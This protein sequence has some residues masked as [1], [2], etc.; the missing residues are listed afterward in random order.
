[1]ITN[2]MGLAKSVVGALA[3]SLLAGPAM[4][5]GLKDGP[6]TPAR[7][8]EWTA[9]VGVTSDYV[10]RGFSQSAEK[11]AVQGGID[12]TYGLF[13][14]GV[15]ASGIDFGENGAGRNIATTEVDLIAGIKPK[16]GPLSFDF[17]VIYYIYPSARDPGAELNYV[18][19][20]AGVSYEP[21]KGATTGST[22]FYSPEYTGKTGDVWTFESS[23]SQE[24]P[25]FGPVTPTFSAL[26]GYQTGN[27]AAFSSVFA[28]GDDNYY[29]WNA[30]VS[31]AF[32]ERFSI[33][34]RY[35]GTSNSDSFCDAFGKVLNCGD[36]VV[37]TAKVT[38]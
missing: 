12:V 14:T 2:K 37:A 28:D 35:W 23:F 20:K 18:E 13:Y 29:Y 6:M 5:Q 16:W 33:D 1:M 24:L 7:A 38:F 25:K 19:V 15:W 9:N 3:I 36:R 4:A 22:V 34:V 27:S 8:L 31:F 26:L 21:W 32:H 17:G 11:P 10:F 30:G